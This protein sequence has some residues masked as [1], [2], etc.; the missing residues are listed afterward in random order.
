M[1]G[2]PAAADVGFL[3]FFFGNRSYFLIAIE[4]GEKPIHINLAPTFSKFYV[5]FGR[6]RL[7]SQKH[8]S[9]VDKSLLDLLE[10]RVG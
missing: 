3:V 9:I 1:V 7:V 10:L 5:L 6:N 4:L 2:V 8:Q